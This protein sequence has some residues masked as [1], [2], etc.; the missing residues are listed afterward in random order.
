M[1]G[2]A[3]LS[4]LGVVALGPQVV[5]GSFKFSLSSVVQCAPVN[6]IFSGSDSNNHSVPTTLTILP[7]LDNV[8]P[9]KVPIP[10]GASNSTGIQLTFI[11]LA[12]GT[13]FIASL[14]D[15]K[16]PTA[17]V[18]DVQKVLND[19]TGAG[20]SS[21]LGS[22]AT[23]PVKFYEFDDELS[24]CEDFT[25]THTTT[26]APNITAFIPQKGAFKV[27]PSNASTTEGKAS[28]TMDG[29]RGVEVVLLLD[30]GDGHLQTTKLITIDGDNT[31]KKTCFPSS[32]KD[33][34]SNNS[35]TSAA[36][37]LPQST[38][39]GIAVGAAVVGL[40]AIL[41]LIYMLR[42]RRRNRRAKDMEFDPA[43]LNRRWPPE[44]KK[45]EFTETP[46]MIAA[47][48]SPFSAGDGFVR[49][50]IYTNE[51]YSTSTMS[52][53]ARTSISSWNQFIPEDQRKTQA[54]ALERGPSVSES[55]F[56]VNTVD[57][58]HILQMATVHQ[59]RP[60]SGPAYQSRA[61]PSTAGTTMTTFDVAKPAIARLVSTRRSGRTSDPPDLPIAVS[62]NNSA[63]QAAIAAIP[64]GYGP[65]SYGSF[66]ESLD[67]DDEDAPRQSDGG[68]GGFPVPSFKRTGNP[69]D[70][71]ESWGNVVEV[72]R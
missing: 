4:V 8:A 31:S 39:I 15:I 12:A 13:R 19:T 34:N 55:R 72:E 57:M 63:N 10:N 6:I 44:E 2:L 60:S 28:Y 26:N 14:D 51:R 36:K 46:A 70:T 25:I 20:D 9:I 29:V 67:Q 48:K 22:G 59:D 54:E 41:L 64:A 17:Q 7:L 1:F 11:P 18:S 35:K 24:Q 52:S 27:P 43:L 37:G 66:G 50:P 23:P 47:P 49:D 62:R 5:L 32:A 61:Q 3:S 65:S 68:I 69:R 45:I 71:S 53:D 42:A 56:S 21:C 16:G 58:Q 30:D 40:L 38:I 33:S